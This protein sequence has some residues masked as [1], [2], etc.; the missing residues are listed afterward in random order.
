MRRTG[1]TRSPRCSPRSQARALVAVEP[2]AA[3]ALQRLAAE[4]GVPPERLGVTGGAALA[5]AGF[6]VPLADLAAAHGATLP[7]VLDG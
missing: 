3:G 1:S 2:A 5:V 6:T 7:A 4:H